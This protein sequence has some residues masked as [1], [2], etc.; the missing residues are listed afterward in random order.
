MANPAPSNSFIQSLELLLVNGGIHLVEAFA[1]LCAGW[2]LATWVKRWVQAGLA[3]LPIDLTLKPLLA[4]LIRYAILIVTIL[5]DM[6]ND[7]D[8]VEKTIVAALSANRFV[9][10]SPPPT[11]VV[12]ALQEY[13]VLMT[14]RA[15][16]KSNDYWAALY[17]MQKEVKAAL[18][19]A[20]I[21][22]AVTRQAVAVRNEPQSPVTTPPGPDAEAAS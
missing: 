11:A 6:V 17:S 10:K 7:L 20:G 8:V 4:S 19:K 1:I 5:V 21:L 16:V 12:Q 22:I 14:A 18:D 9:A 13:G 2:M 15:Y 3:H